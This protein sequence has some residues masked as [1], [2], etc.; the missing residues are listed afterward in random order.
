M[1]VALKPL[2]ER[3]EIGGPGDRA[4]AAEARQGAGR[5][6]LPAAG[7][8]H[9]H[10]RAAGQRAVPV[11]AAGRRSRRAARVGA[12]DPRCAVQPARSSPTSTPTRRTRGCRPRWSSTATPRRGSAS[13]RGMIDTT[14][15]DLFGQR[16]VSTIYAQLNQYHVVMEAAP[17]YWQSPDALKTCLRQHAQRRAGAAVDVRHATARPTR[18]S[19]STTRASSSRRRSRSTCRRMSRCRRPRARS[20]TRWRASACPTRSAAASRAARARSRRRSPASR[21]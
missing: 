5:Q 10:R 2:S 12:E 9:P 11:H 21:G 15:N 3:K 14:L 17:E 4:A 20:R 19:A 7:A 13:P 16:Q 6:P 8:G 18:R 1:F